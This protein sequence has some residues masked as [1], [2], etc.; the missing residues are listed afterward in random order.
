MMLGWGTSSYTNTGS[1]S[2]PS[3]SSSPV[4]NPPSSFTAKDL[5]TAGANLLS[6]IVS[7]NASAI[8]PPNNDARNSTSRADQ[9]TVR[10][11]VATSK[12]SMVVVVRADATVSDFL[13]TVSGKIIRGFPVGSIVLNPQP[14]VAAMSRDGYFYDEDDLVRHAFD[15]DSE[16]L[17]LTNDE[18]RRVLRTQHDPFFSRL[19]H[20]N[21]STPTTTVPQHMLPVTASPAVSHGALQL[22]HHPHDA[23]DDDDGPHPSPFP[24]SSHLAAGSPQPSPAAASAATGFPQHIPARMRAHSLRS[25]A[26]SR[27]SSVVGSVLQLA[28]TGGGGDAMAGGLDVWEM[29]VMGSLGG[30]PILPPPGARPLVYVS[31][32]RLN[33]ARMM[34]GDRAVGTCDPHWIYK[35][36]K[37]AG[38]SVFI[39]ESE[40]EAGEPLSE[41]LV[42]MM[43]KATHFVT[44]LSKEYAS[45]PL[46]EAEFK[47]S[48]FKKRFVVLV[49]T[50]P[51]AQIPPQP[52]GKLSTAAHAMAKQSRRR[53][54]GFWGPSARPSSMIALGSGAGAGPSGLAG[55]VGATAGAPANA[56]AS[57]VAGTAVGHMVGGG[58][59]ACID[60]RDPAK[61]NKAMTA[62][63]AALRGETEVGEKLLASSTATTLSRGY[64]SRASL[65]DVHAGGPAGAATFASPDAVARVL[66]TIVSE[67]V[68]ARRA[69]RVLTTAS[70][71][72]AARFG[73]KRRVTA[74]GGATMVGP[75][76]GALPGDVFTVL[77]W[78][79]GEED[80]G[81]PE[82]AVARAT[83]VSGPTARRGRIYV[84]YCWDNSASA[85]KSM[86][87]LVGVG[88]GVCDPRRVAARLAAAGFEVWMDVR[89]KD[90]K[91]IAKAERRV[92]RMRRR[93]E[94]RRRRARVE[95][96]AGGKGEGVEGEGLGDEDTEEDN[97]A[98][99]SSAGGDDEE[100]DRSPGGSG[101]DT[102]D[103]DP[104]TATN[105]RHNGGAP[106]DSDDD[107][108]DGGDELADALTLG[109]DHA[110]CMIAFISDE[111]ASSPQLSRE[112]HFAHNV[113][114]LPL[115]PVVVGVGLGNVWRNGPLGAAVR[116]YVS[117]D[118]TVGDVDL[119]HLLKMIYKVVG[120]SPAPEGPRR[121]PED[122]LPASPASAPPGVAGDDMGSGMLGNGVPFSPGPPSSSGSTASFAGFGGRVGPP[123]PSG[124]EAVG[125]GEMIMSP[126]GS[127]A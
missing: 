94:E 24:S 25:P 97:T 106:T 82:V 22:T 7:L 122:E 111:F 65:A 10:I 23:H 11:K 118:A 12:R 6:S 31:F 36:L 53:A 102:D 81:V 5:S 75:A 127:D 58:D 80:D 95:G 13:D 105:G 100:D 124:L 85:M 19:I 74:A 110:D 28:S 32:S 70:M 57:Y 84:A 66:R 38:F 72:T 96:V 69:V 86:G 112:F 59:V 108:D 17:A 51:A 40:R 16:V 30:A 39:D 29:M 90:V 42:D 109:M 34:G 52:L 113:L 92:E 87:Q 60:F 123:P 43:L 125:E 14:V 83:V 27:R 48:R 55:G 21:D 104:T 62:L 41:E 44:C 126:T 117:I 50:S 35:G 115:I 68:V 114:R 1:S 47:F 77:G 89:R 8:M 46:C 119:D 45:S 121:D 26:H 73:V 37:Q 79:G 3:S 91:R 15:T 120:A 76:D 54:S 63:V 67:D 33:S 116:G 107:D 9:G 103:D 61:M 2:T 101:S 64:G 88:A 49:G 78:D 98:P 20:A 18:L 93:L 71:A 99:M 56:V 4:N